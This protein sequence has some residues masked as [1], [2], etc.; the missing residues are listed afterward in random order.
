MRLVLVSAFI[1][2]LLFGGLPGVPPACAEEAVSV[3][4][5]EKEDSET[6]R[7]SAFPTD[8]KVGEGFDEEAL[9]EEI[10][11]AKPVE[12]KAEIHISPGYRFLHE[13]SYGRRA[14]EYT[15]LRSGFAGDAIFRSVGPELKINLDGFFLNENDYLGDLLFDL[16]GKYRMQ[17][18]TESLFHNLDHEQL[19][20][21]PF[22]LWGVTYTPMELKPAE[23]YGVRV[24]QDLVRLRLMPWEYP[25]HV[26]LG[27]WRMTKDGT[28][29]L[30]YEGDTSGGGKNINSTSR[31]VKRETM[32]G[33]IGFDS[34]LGYLD[35]FYSFNVR[36][37]ANHADNPRNAQ[38]HNV[39]PDSRL[40]SHTV[41]LHTSLTGGVAGAFSYTHSTRRNINELRDIS[42]S[43]HPENRLQNI[44]G[45]LSY[46]P[47]AW[48]AASVKYRHQETDA[49]KISILSTVT[50]S[51]TIKSPIETRKDLATVTL[52]VRPHKMLTLKGEY[53]GGVVHRGNTEQWPDLPEHTD[54]HRGSLTLLG[55]LKNG[56]RA[57]ARYEYATVSNPAYGNF[58]TDRHDGQL[59]FTYT[60][61][62][63]W[64]VVANY[65][66]T[67]ERND[68]FSLSSISSS[69]L[70][71][72]R[73]VNN[74]TATLWINPTDK[75]TLTGTYGFLR[76]RAD[77]EVLFTNSATSRTSTNFTSQAQLY[78]VGLTYRCT[79]RF[80]LALLFQQVHSVAEFDPESNPS[81]DTSNIREQS[82]SRT[83][84]TSA[85]ARAG[86]F[87]TR[88]FNCSLEYGY[89]RYNEKN[90]QLFDGTVQTVTLMLTRKW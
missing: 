57:K 10:E 35:I 66:I 40:L 78:S 50:P 85:S 51:I 79:D 20:D 7:S 12:T 41:K 45:E 37:F 43:A 61:K 3:L 83:I 30:I 13:T 86:Y 42:L 22:L 27:F 76:S 25:F 77:Q 67:Q 64:G 34:H 53:R 28:R 21:T 54:I 47:K 74:A 56:F 9:I 63:R 6:S 49:D 82:Q 48:F 72:D 8:L 73:E 39:D 2:V 5:V 81:Q 90:S 4:P 55:R 26:N 46:I 38:E 44:A 17:F 32:D 15:F 88:D 59:L 29:Q 84:E 68:E 11:A 31:D 69:P 65:R 18:R 33:T 87:F 80:D 89:R 1:S 71:R 60:S 75:V 58:Y 24:E 36:D 52:S 70:T 62:N 19:F 23:R 16:R 14:A